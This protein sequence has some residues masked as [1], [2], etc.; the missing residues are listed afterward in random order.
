VFYVILVGKS[1]IVITADELKFYEILFLRLG[2]FFIAC[3][4]VCPAVFAV[5]LPFSAVFASLRV[6]CGNL[7]GFTI[8]R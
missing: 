1:D 8:L 2:F 4:Y 6:K 7:I 3:Q 5:F